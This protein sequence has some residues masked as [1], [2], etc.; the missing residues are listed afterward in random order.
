MRSAFCC[1]VPI[2][3]IAVVCISDSTASMGEL[4]PS[5]A[6]SALNGST[7]FS[8]CSLNLLRRRKILSARVSLSN[9]WNALSYPFHH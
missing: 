8:N 7:V 4:A 3:S 9:D 6:I 2:F 1:G 5:A